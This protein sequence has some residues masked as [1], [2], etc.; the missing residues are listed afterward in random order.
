MVFNP[1]L[2]CHRVFSG[3]RSQT[4]QQRQQ[5]LFISEGLRFPFRHRAQFAAQRLRFG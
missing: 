4:A 5:G 1:F 2:V 3:R